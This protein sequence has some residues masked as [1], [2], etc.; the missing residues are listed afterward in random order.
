MSIDGIKYTAS[1][2]KAKNIIPITY[3]DAVLFSLM[4]SSQAHTGDDTEKYCRLQQVA[5]FTTFISHP[6]CIC[7]QLS[8]AF[9]AWLLFFYP[10]SLSA[11][12]AR[13]AKHSSQN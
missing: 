1:L 7:Q 13:N 10:G 9:L 11:T 6:Y 5:C 2:T 4:A 8:W 3:P 12:F